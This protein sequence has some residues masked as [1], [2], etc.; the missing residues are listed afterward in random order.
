M[1]SYF[2]QGYELYFSTDDVLIFICRM[3]SDYYGISDVDIYKDNEENSF[4][5]N[6]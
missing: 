5:I 1:A 4:R 3:C 6:G 2:N